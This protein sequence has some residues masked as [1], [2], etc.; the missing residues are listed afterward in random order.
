MKRSRTGFPLAV[1]LLLA[2]SAAAPAAAQATE[3][4][5]EETLPGFKPKQVYDAN[6]VDNV[7]LHN[8]DP[9]LV[10]PLGPEYPLGPG[11]SWRL[12]AYYSARIWHLSNVGCPG[13]DCGPTNYFYRGH[14]G[15]NPAL[16]VGWTL[17]MGTII[18]PDPSLPFDTIH[19][20]RSPDGA[21]HELNS[22]GDGFLYTGPPLS[23]RVR[24]DGNGYLL[25]R[26]DGTRLRFYHPYYPPTPA[27]GYDFSDLDRDRQP[28]ARYGLTEMV[29]PFDT[30]LMTVHYVN[31]TTPTSPD[32][33]KVSQVFLSGNRAVNFSWGSWQ[34]FGVSWPVLA[35]VTFPVNGGGTLTTTLTFL[36]NDNTLATR[37]NRTALDWGGPSNCFPLAA[38]LREISAPI[39]TAVTTASHAY[40]FRYRLGNDAEPQ[41]ILSGFTTPT[42]SKVD[43]TYQT[44]TVNVPCMRNAS[45]CGNP[46][47]EDH[48][49][50]PTA[51]DTGQQVCKPVARYHRFLEAAAAVVLRTETDLVTGLVAS[52][53][54]YR[55]G[56]S[57]PD[58]SE[59]PAVPDA[60]R[61][62]RQ[63]IVRRPDGVGGTI[64]TKHLFSA[65]T[66][67]L[68]GFELERRYY[69]GTAAGD[70]ASPVRTN[71][72]CYE[73]NPGGCGVLDSQ[74]KI[75]DIAHLDLLRRNREVTWYGVNPPGGGDCALSTTPACWQKQLLSWDPD[76]EE[77]GTERISSNSSF[78]LYDDTGPT[79][80]S[81]RYRDRTTEWSPVKTS[82]I[83][84][85]K[86][87]TS[88]RVFESFYSGCPFEP[89]SQATSYSFD[90][91]NGFLLTSS[92][93]DNSYGTLSRTRE[94]DP[95]G[96]LWK[97]TDGGNWSGAGSFKTTR[98]FQNGLPLT[99]IRDGL[100]V[101][102]YQFNVA[103]DAST[104][105]IT[106][107]Y[108]PN[109]FTTAYQ[110]DSLG[111]LTSVTPPG[112]VATTYCYRDWTPGSPSQGAYVLV[113]KGASSA[114]NLNDGVPGA[115]SGAFEAFLFD[116]NG[117]LIKEFRRAPNLL[118]GGS[119]FSFRQTGY[120]NADHVT[121]SSE[122]I[123]CP[124]GASSTNVSVCFSAIAPIGNATRFSQF[125]F[126]GRPK[127]IDAPDGNFS[128]KSYDD[129]TLFNSDTFEY[130]ATS[131]VGG[132][133]VY[134][135][136]RK[137]IFGR[138]LIVAEPGPPPFG[139]YSC[140]SYNTLDKL[141]FANI[142]C[143]SQQNRTFAHDKFG[144]LRSEF[145]PE[146][147]TTS[148]LEYD[149][150]GNVSKKR[151]GGVNYRYANDTLGRPLTVKADA[152]ASP[153]SEPTT[154]YVENF[155][156]GVAGPAGGSPK[157]RLTRRIG[158]NPGV[159][160]SSLIKVA[161]DLTYAGLGG[162]PSQ[163]TTTI[164]N[165]AASTTESWT[166]NSLGL[167]AS[168]SYPRIDPSSGSSWS[169]RATSRAYPPPCRRTVK[170]S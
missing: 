134:G 163:K 25:W 73:G 112:E 4:Q 76:A 141:A 9:Q 35:S 67:S 144:F 33:W 97:Q 155:W 36:A 137:D 140:Y 47:T 148:Y 55:R 24:W 110:Y 104:G 23:L 20:Y 151:E 60:L 43:Y 88:K 153:S 166:Y 94:K 19:H 142:T 99:S 123:P 170:P 58:Y 28:W 107:S 160:P 136:F 133:I 85:P 127:R 75:L 131:F 13:S 14:V 129:G 50:P 72:N 89:C 74:G 158:R 31:E 122:W 44:S 126:L 154:A 38:T 61:I 22:R 143:S 167:V 48:S 121:F 101:P 114:C 8:G 102:W 138:T 41:G 113:K 91:T 156:D 162:R 56:Y 146:K 17:E 109:F 78:L 45:G 10:V 83:Y 165:G 79:Q 11:S 164:S 63:V 26:P 5:P 46:E 96:N 30:T 68:P 66:V 16:G 81:T 157:G 103:R 49:P 168:E 82:S 32:A 118:P 161:E 117:R 92:I 6:P 139:P 51:P 40:S 169:R 149:A 54:Y 124:S 128:T 27:N 3:S 29:D 42:G 93:F 95:A 120:D 7:N 159:Y 15:G 18:P 111:R 37:F 108:D 115:G 87:F 39:L 105:L 57:E 34:G 116:G 52:T 59:I 64:A 106:T 80:P 147:G 1:V 132:Q 152:L 98:T 21:E 65:S 119:Y 2:V 130:T 70:S 53:S 125:D 69:A 145:H 71:V 77:F 62:V 90:T 86:L 100:A 12:R 150:L 84:L 135:A